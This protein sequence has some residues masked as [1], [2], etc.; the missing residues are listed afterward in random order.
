MIDRASGLVLPL[1]HHLVQ[2]GLQRFGPSVAP[3]VT[4][5]DRELRRC[6]KRGS[7]VVSQPAPHAT[8]HTDGNGLQLPT[9][10]LGVV[11]RVPAG[12]LRREGLVFG[13]HLLA[14]RRFLR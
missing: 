5:T 1:M 14:P 4:P 10:M 13:T 8:R 9:E 11:A 2:Q 12:E 6:S 7:R 3:K